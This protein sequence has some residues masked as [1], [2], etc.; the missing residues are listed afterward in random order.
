MK[1]KLRVMKSN[2]VNFELC[3]KSNYVKF[4][5]ITHVDF[6]DRGLNGKY[7]RDKFFEHGQ[8]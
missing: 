1:S 5:S 2:Y 3:M 6:Q 8:K 4:K 7:R